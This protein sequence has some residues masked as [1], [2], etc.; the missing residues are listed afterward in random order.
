AVTLL[1]EPDSPTMATVSRA[2]TSKETLR[3][4]GIHRVSRMNEVVRPE[5]D[6]TGV[7]ILCL[8]DTRFVA[9][10]LFRKTGAYFCGTCVSTRVPGRPGPAGIRRGS[11]RRWFRARIQ[12]PF[13]APSCW[14]YAA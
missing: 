12:P 9:H 5:I 6:R 14:R 3:T 4:T 11:G 2:A 8:S 13:P 1:P 7:L 10:V